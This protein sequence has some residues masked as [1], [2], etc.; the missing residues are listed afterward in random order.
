MERRRAAELRQQR[1]PYVG[2]LRALEARMAA[3]VERRQAL[4]ALLA[5]ET[6]YA[7]S[8]KMR[9]QT[10]LRER[11]KLDA[12]LAAAEEEWLAAA[13]ELE[14]LDLAIGWTAPA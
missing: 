13:A 4:D 12:E 11:A 8:E 1:Q 9:L 14:A 7:A 3:L 10:S 5:G 2:R 6:L